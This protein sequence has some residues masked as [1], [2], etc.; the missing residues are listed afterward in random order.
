VRTFRP[1]TRLRRPLHHDPATPVATFRPQIDDPVSFGDHIQVVLDDNDAV[2]GL[3]QAVQY[4]DEFF[5]VGH[6]QADGGLIQHVERLFLAGL[7]EF[8]DELQALR[9]AA[10]ERR[11]LLAQGEVAQALLNN[12]EAAALAAAT[13]YRTLFGPDN[14]WLELQH[15]LLPDD[16]R[17]VGDLVVGVVGAFI[18]GFLFSFLGLWPNGGLIG[19]IVVATIGAVV[20]LVIVRAIKRA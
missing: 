1:G 17:L 16:E 4:A 9:L 2:A 5:H 20:L 19:S 12:D 11:A 15:H 13:Y 8:G 7:G 10:R 14:F 6:V 3:D 18:G